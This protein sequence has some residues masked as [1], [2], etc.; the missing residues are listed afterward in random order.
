MSD[1]E[2]E[3]EESSSIASSTED[4]STYGLIGYRLEPEYTDSALQK[5]RRSCQSRKTHHLPKVNGKS[6]RLTKVTRGNLGRAK[7]MAIPASEFSEAFGFPLTFG[8][9]QSD[10]PVTSHAFD[11]YFHCFRLWPRTNGTNDS[12]RPFCILLLQYDFLYDVTSPYGK[13]WC[14]DKSAKHSS[15]CL[16]RQSVFVATNFHYLRER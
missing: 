8:K 4:I 16:Y 2:F 10:N 6:K 1:S 13:T 12:L 15:L 7:K 14:R 5:N 11:M 9:C 3:N